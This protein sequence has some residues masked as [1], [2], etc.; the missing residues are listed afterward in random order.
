M[1]R[2][3]LILAVLASAA[4]RAGGDSTTL[5]DSSPYVRDGGHQDNSIYEAFSLFARAEGNDWLKDIRIVARGWGRLTLGTSFDNHTTAGDGDSLFLE[6]RV[7]KR[8]LLL[9]V[10]RQLMTGGAIRGAPGGGATPHGGGA[11]RPPA[12]ASAG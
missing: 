8:H 10:G 3:A 5:Y 11:Y 7:L 9:R 1:L 12:P 6:G 2:K 4:A